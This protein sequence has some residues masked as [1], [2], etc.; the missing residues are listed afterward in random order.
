VR[1]DGFESRCTDVEPV[2]VEVRFHNDRTM[3][4][5]TKRYSCVPGRVP[6]LLS[7]HTEPYPFRRSEQEMAVIVA[8]AN[9]GIN[10]LTEDDVEDWSDVRWDL[11]GPPP[12]TTEE[13]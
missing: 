9:G 8:L 1:F 6:V 2:E 5:G 4:H 11:R 12:Q 7:T 13:P 10:V 3:G